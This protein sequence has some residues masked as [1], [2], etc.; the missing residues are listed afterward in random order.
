[1]DC[2]QKKIKEAYESGQVNPSQKKLKKSNNKDLDEAVQKHALKK[3]S[4]QRK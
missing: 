4:C 3:D 1:M 2:K